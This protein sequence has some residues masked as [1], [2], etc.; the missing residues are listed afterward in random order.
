MTP[1]Q[2]IEYL[3]E[4]GMSTRDIANTIGI[5]QTQVQRVRQHG[6]GSEATRVEQFEQL[7]KE[8][9]RRP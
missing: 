8:W 9:N 1:Q 7:R 5:S 3:Q 4:R 6:N 2:K